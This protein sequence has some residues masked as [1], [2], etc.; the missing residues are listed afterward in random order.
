MAQTPLNIGTVANDGTGDGLRDTFEKIEANNTELYSVG[1]W[2]YYKD[3][4]TTPA[5]QTFTTTP[6]KLQIDGGHANSESGYLPREIRGSSELWDVVNDKIL[7]INT[8]D[9]YDIRVELTID[10]ITASA[11][12]LTLELDIGSGFSPSVVIYTHE[13][14]KPKTLPA[15]VAYTFPIFCLSTFKSNG[16]QI[17]F[18][19]DGGTM[20]CS[21]FAILIKR[22]YNGS[23]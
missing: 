7:P 5:T 11:A 13:L 20:V 15:T 17:F 1:G 23:T 9:A 6:A 21:D 4:G 3:A 16:G 22:D 12:Y 18:H 8:G 19:T 2:A 14:I 10:S